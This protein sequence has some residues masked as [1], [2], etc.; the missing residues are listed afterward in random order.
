MN[1][2][3]TDTKA[4]EQ[5]NELF[6]IG[7][8]PPRKKRTTRFCSQQCMGAARRHRGQCQSCGQEIKATRKFCSRECW[9]VGRDRSRHLATYTCLRCGKPF[10]RYASQV[11]DP[12]RVYCSSECRA[13]N[14]VYKRGAEHPQ[15]KPEGWRYVN[16]SGYVTVG[17]G[18]ARILEHRLVMQRI[19]GRPL[20]SHETVH[21]I[22]GDKRD[23]RPENLQLRTG[24]HGKG[25]VSTCAD[26]GSHNIV[27]AQIG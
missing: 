26:C 19:F 6:P 4:C 2:P 18:D 20:E 10:Q 17:R 9:Q 13:A 23:N 16:S 11:R 24:R 27:G 12:K 7:G 25:V 8:R 15:Y 21:H 14:R 5:C 3:A 22:N 1:A